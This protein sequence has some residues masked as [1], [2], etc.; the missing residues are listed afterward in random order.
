M[1]MEC[2]SIYLYLLAF[3]WVVFCRS[4]YK[5]SISLV[6]FISKCFIPFLRVQL[7]VEYVTE[8]V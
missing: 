7:F 4:V 5:S 3:L 8:E 1:D 6:K 2:L